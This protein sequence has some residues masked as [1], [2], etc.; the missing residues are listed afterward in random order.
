MRICLLKLFLTTNEYLIVGACFMFNLHA[1]HCKKERKKINNNLTLDLQQCYVS[2][3]SICY[4]HFPSVGILLLSL[5]FST[6]FVD[7]ILVKT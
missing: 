3:F 4:L 5:C 2:L 7:R 6:A 1:I